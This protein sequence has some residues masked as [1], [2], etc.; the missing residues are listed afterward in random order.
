MLAGVTRQLIGRPG[1]AYAY[2]GNVGPW[3]VPAAAAARIEA[4]GNALATRFGLV[5]LF[6]VDLQLDGD[7][8]PWAV[9]VNPRYTAGVEVLEL[10]TGR[11]LAAEH[12]AA[13]EGGSARPLG[14]PEP[15]RRTC[16]AKEVLF[17]PWPVEIDE[18]L[19]ADH[20]FSEVDP[21]RV[22]R[23][24]DVPNVGTRS[25]AGDPVLTV[26]AEG[27]TPLV[28]LQR[29]ARERGAWEQRLAACRD[30][31]RLIGNR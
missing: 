18:N 22:P 9:E 3:P 10:A 2:R 12:V 15:T 16:V 25:A 19:L 26:F 30:R 13:C 7:A 1:A 23:V 28:A 24:A 8:I 14:Q 21:F 27:P 31:R 20:K 17:A 4:M 29:L 11:A 5:G 6:G